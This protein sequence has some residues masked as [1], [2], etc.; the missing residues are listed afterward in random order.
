MIRRPPRSTL[1]PYTTLFRSCVRYAS[2]CASGV[3]RRVVAQ[4]IVTCFRHTGAHTEARANGVE[5]NNVFAVLRRAFNGSG[6]QPF[7]L[8]PHDWF[9]GL[10]HAN[11]FA[12]A[13][14]DGIGARYLE[15]RFWYTSACSPLRARGACAC[16]IVA[17]L[18]YTSDI[19]EARVDSIGVNCC[20]SCARSTVDDGCC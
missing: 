1:F 19:T 9:A 13:C 5:P 10:R 20:R 15:P 11:T 16:A 17:G 14:A 12:E 2:T 8:E 7:G 3:A 4:R 6:R 18:R